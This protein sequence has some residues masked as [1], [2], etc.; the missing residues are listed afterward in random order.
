MLTTMSDVCS[1]LG[2]AQA[3]I[4]ILLETYVRYFICLVL[5]AFCAAVKAAPVAP[6]R[7]SFDFGP[8]I[9]AYIDQPS[10]FSDVL[11]KRTCRRWRGGV[12]QLRWRRLPGDG[13]SA[14][15]KSAPR[16]EALMN[17]SSL[18]PFSRNRP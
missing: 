13:R 14:G 9:R 16:S 11:R 3:R 1:G 12:W 7:L 5:L 15:W 2:T 17:S 18:P 8:S 6:E 4:S 10:R